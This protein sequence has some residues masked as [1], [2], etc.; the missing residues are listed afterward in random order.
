MNAFEFYRRQRL[1]TQSDVAMALNVSRS[2]V[3]KWETGAAFPSSGKLSA[4]ANLF[5]CTIDDLL[6]ERSEKSKEASA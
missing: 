3:T 4:I 5:N 6:R 1:M 2:T